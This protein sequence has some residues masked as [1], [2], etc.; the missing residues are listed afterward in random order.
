MICFINYV[1]FDKS[2]QNSFRKQTSLPDYMRQKFALAQG[3]S[4]RNNAIFLV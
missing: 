2:N 4:Y 3:C 1:K